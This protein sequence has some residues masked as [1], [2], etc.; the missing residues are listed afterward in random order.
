MLKARE[1]RGRVQTMGF[2]KGTVYCLEALAE[3]QSVIRQE[4]RML[5][6]M[7]D[8]MID[9]VTQLAAVGENMKSAVG[10]LH[11]I[12]NG[13]DDEGQGPVSS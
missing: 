11:R 2:E 3:Q 10:Q 7:L 13:A 5:A 12:V 4:A 8:Q 9:I 6:Q 1:V